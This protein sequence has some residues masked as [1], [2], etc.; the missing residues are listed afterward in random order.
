SASLHLFLQLALR[1]AGSNFSSAQSKLQNP[2]TDC[3]GCLNACLQIAGCDQGLHRIGEYVVALAESTL[4]S[5]LSKA[6]HERESVL[7][8]KTAQGLRADNLRT[9]TGQLSLRRVLPSL[10][11]SLTHHEIKDRVSEKFQTL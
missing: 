5:P 7:A 1:I 8:R 11:E 3:P 10:V 4:T 9:R 2:E 6:Q